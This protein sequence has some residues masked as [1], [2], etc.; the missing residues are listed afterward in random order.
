MFDNDRNADHKLR[1]W[2]T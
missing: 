1:I 2:L